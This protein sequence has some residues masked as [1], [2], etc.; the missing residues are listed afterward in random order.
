M[1]TTQS[2]LVQKFADGATRGKAS[3][4]F[5]DGDGLYSY[6]HHFPLAIRRTDRRTVWYLLNG[7]RYSVT[8]SRH[9][10][11]TF[12][13]FRDSPRVSFRALGAAGIDARKCQLIGFWPDGYGDRMYP[14][15]ET[16][17][18]GDGFNPPDGAITGQETW[19]DGQIRRFWHRIGSVALR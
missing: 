12:R 7:D 19:S 14:D 10:S 4:M 1:A 9:Q 13:V 2:T 15:V 6:G 18:L 11:E 17:K 3:A 8:T 5:V 16:A